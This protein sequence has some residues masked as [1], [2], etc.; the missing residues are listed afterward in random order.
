M[1]TI[2]KLRFS[3]NVPKHGWVR[4][5]GAYFYGQAPRSSFGVSVC[6]RIPFI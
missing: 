1:L 4:L 2:E 6:Y 3:R 5:H